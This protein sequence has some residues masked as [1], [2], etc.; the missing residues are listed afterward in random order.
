MVGFE[1]HVGPL[2]AMMLTELGRLLGPLLGVGDTLLLKGEIGAGKSHFCRSVIAEKLAQEGRVEDI[3][4]PSF[5]LVQSYDLAAHEIWHV[6]LYRLSGLQETDEL[7]L[8]DAMD[9][10]LMLIE[11]PERLGQ[12]QPAE[13]LALEIT[14]AEGGGRFVH[15]S[16]THAKW[17]PVFVMLEAIDLRASLVKTLLGALGYQPD[18][19]ALLAA[20][21]SNRRYFRLPTSA[22]P[23]VVMDAPPALGEK[24]EPFLAVTACLRAHG[25]S[26]PEVFHADEEAGVLVLED[27]GDAL[28][29]TLAAR[30][31]AIETPIYEAAVDVLVQL[32]QKPMAGLAPYDLGCYQREARLVV[33]WY[34]VSG[35]VGAARA[36]LDALIASL[37]AEL[38]MSTLTLRDYHAQNL[39]WLPDRGGIARVG[40]L[41]Y[42][43]ALNG[44]PAYDLVSLLEDARRDVPA[45]LQ[46]AMM[47]RYL[48]KTGRGEAAFRRAYCVLGAQRNLKIIGIFARL[49]LRD[50]KPHYLDM[51]PRVYAYLMQDLAHPE[52]A[53]LQR[54]VL[55]EIPPPEVGYLEALRLRAGE[56]RG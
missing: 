24:T 30:D 7:G 20:D 15:L 16:A 54:F 43:D 18:S 53:D 13:A 33:D 39:L 49:A 42:Q 52:L 17:Q 41:D 29:A 36:E 51:I 5:T 34:G 44:H 9:A 4:S 22:G 1:A 38:E 14:P 25:L 32:H 55:R 37:C 19:L 6:D 2:D 50:G 28:Y 47:A 31:P 48:E 45:S 26:A 23:L 8:W 27:L 40:L 56:G 10:V 3:P 11:W 46:E 12:A 21:A 35:N